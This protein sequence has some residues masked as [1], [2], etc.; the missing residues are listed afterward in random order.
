M[1]KLQRPLLIMVYKLLKTISGY[2]T[3]K[4][5]ALLLRRRN[6]FYSVKQILIPRCFYLLRFT[7]QHPRALHELPLIFKVALQTTGSRSHS[8]H[9]LLD[10]RKKNVI[11]SNI[12]NMLH[13]QHSTLPGRMY[14]FTHDSKTEDVVL[15][16]K[17][18]LSLFPVRQ[19]I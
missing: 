14:K 4:K 5:I 16:G 12:P 11:S 8:I 10:E 17:Q 13:I 19:E 15:V 18:L 9:A 3:E 2:E 7:S 6:L 1:N